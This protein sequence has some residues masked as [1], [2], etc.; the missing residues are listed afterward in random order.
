MRRTWGCKGWPGLHV[1]NPPVRVT[2]CWVG[3]DGA[4]ERSGFVCVRADDGLYCVRECSNCKA[5]PGS[6]P[7]VA[8]IG[9]TGELRG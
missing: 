1:M 7:L 3:L 9:T 5:S 6:P 8:G 2:G 4:I